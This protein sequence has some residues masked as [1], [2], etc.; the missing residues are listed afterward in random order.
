[1]QVPQSFLSGKC[2]KYIFNKRKLI[3]NE[4]RK[5]YFKS[6][7]NSTPTSNEQIST[8]NSAIATVVFA[9]NLKHVAGPGHKQQT[10][11]KFEKSSSPASVYQGFSKRKTTT[12]VFDLPSGREQNGLALVSC[13]LE[14][15]KVS[16]TKTSGRT[17]TARPSISMASRQQPSEKHNAGVVSISPINILPK[18]NF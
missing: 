18:N 17:T 12:T 8:P 10:V 14:E 13:S 6:F 5:N 7:D 2:A 16:T 1:M 11:S 15:L 4:Q 3:D 9:D